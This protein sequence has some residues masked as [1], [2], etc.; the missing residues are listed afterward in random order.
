M[1]LATYATAL[2]I[3]LFPSLWP[4][5]AEAYAR[6]DYDWV[7][8]VFWKAARYAM[9][10]AGIAVVVLALFGRPL[11]RWYVGAAA[12][13]SEALILTICVW[14]LIATGMDLEAC[15]LSALGRVKLQAVLSLV[16]AVINIALSIYWVRTLGSVGVILGT[17]ASYL[18]VLVGAQSVLVWKALYRTPAGSHELSPA[19]RALVFPVLWMIVILRAGRGLRMLERLG[20]L[21]VKGTRSGEPQR[22]LVVYLTKHLGDLVL[23]LPM[24]EKLRES[25]PSARIEVAVQKSAKSLFDALSSV[26]CVW[27]FDVQGDSART[28]RAALRLSWKITREYLRLMVGEA[29]PDVCILPRWLDDSLRS[30]ELA[31]LTRA[32]RRI[33]FK[34]LMFSD[35][36]PFADRVLTDAVTGGN[37]MR[38]P[39]KPLYLL[40]SVGVLPESDLAELGGQC[41]RSLQEIADGVNWISLAKRVGLDPG[42]RFAV[43]APG[44]AEVRRTWPP[45]RWA[46]VGL[47]LKRM[48]FLVVTLS[49]PSDSHMAVELNDLLE[50]Q[51]EG[52]SI[53]VAGVTSI[54]ETVAL[55]S[56]CSVYLGADS[57][58]GHV[59][60]GLGVPTIGQFI[61]LAGSDPDCGHAPERFRPVG[62]NVTCIQIPRTVDPCVE[63]CSSDRQ[64]CIL[65]I[66]TE[67]MLRAVREALAIPVGAI[68]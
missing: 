14:T 40:Q 55:L 10:A 11:L 22:I 16:A 24:I 65:T 17:I 32:P 62:P 18:L 7:R 27:A 54:P 25:Y 35:R 47:M 26:D 57:G 68:D 64:H 45:E 21:R 38:E 67:Q 23:I 41:I 56:H 43:I 42:R 58:P 59:A 4:A 20:I 52:G 60:G 31:Y 39:A 30:P 28:W 3:A 12:V 36:L 8:Q 13:P 51:D 66:E 2:Q 19:L 37:G 6:G 5:Y 1:R 9:G 29:P 50:Q 34:W 33:G 63:A 44:A 61:T 46:E 15:L 53:A 48:D 49:G